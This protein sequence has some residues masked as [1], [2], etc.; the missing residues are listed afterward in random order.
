[1]DI[2][3]GY[4][5]ISLHNCTLGPFE[6]IQSFLIPATTDFAS[7]SRVLFSFWQLNGRILSRPDCVWGVILSNHLIVVFPF[8][9][10]HKNRFQFWSL[11]AFLGFAFRRF[12]DS[13]NSPVRFCYEIQR[14]VIQ[15]SNP[16]RPVHLLKTCC[17]SKVSLEAS[18]GARTGR[19][20]R[21]EPSII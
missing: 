13:M 20:S 11:Q 4:R 1:M 8:L 17:L 2:E 18:V 12:N 21:G 14:F 19:I 3:K 6:R 16:F 7:D 10:A 15:T 5:L 9:E